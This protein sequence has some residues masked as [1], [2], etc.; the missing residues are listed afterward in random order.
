MTQ[1]NELFYWPWVL[2][3]LLSLPVLAQYYQKAQKEKAQNISYHPDL[4]LLKQAS[5]QQ[6]KP[7]KLATI[8][9]SLAIIIAII[10][11]ARPTLKV[12]EAHPQAGIMLALDVSRSMAAYD[13]LPNR[14]EAAKEAIKSFVKNLPEGTRVGLVVFAG[15]ATPI[16]PLSQDHDRLI[17]A[18]DYLRMDYGAVIG[19]GLISSLKSLPSLEQRLNLGDSP[20]RFATIILLSDG[21]NFGGIDPLSALEEVKQQQV[22]VHTIGV[23]TLTDGPIPGIPMQYQFAARFDEPTMRKIATDTGGTFNFVGSA[24]ELKEVYED[25]S[26][27]VI[28]RFGKDEATAIGTLIAAFLLFVSLSLSLFRKSIF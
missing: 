19:E 20:E 6:K 15:Y 2:I 4:N 24:E 1:L 10:S 5:N 12:P 16:V 3:A 26:R 27:A 21:R 22:T 9:F 13:I 17:E 25:L 28:W 8:L 18:I 11:L 7:A 14:F 23:G